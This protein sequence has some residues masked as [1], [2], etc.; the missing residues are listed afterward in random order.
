[1]MAAVMRR[2]CKKYQTSK[3]QV[4]N[5]RNVSNNSETVVDGDSTSDVHCNHR[6]EKSQVP[7]LVNSSSKILNSK[8]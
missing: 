2:E 4:D 3:T 6:E 1:M 7:E 8:G 5:G